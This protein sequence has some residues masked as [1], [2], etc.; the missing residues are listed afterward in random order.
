MN[1]QHTLTVNNVK[2]LG[3]KATS[4]LIKL[5]HDVIRMIKD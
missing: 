4:N 5:M 1:K 2:A 3:L